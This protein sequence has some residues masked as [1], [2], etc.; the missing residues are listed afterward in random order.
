MT[1]NF[2]QPLDDLI[3]MFMRT[4][5][6]IPS[7]GMGSDKMGNQRCQLFFLNIVYLLG[8]YIVLLGVYGLL[9]TL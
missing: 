6:Q 7:P 9:A 2:G 5:N 1:F 4:H 3:R 8:F